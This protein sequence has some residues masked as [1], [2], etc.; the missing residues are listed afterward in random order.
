MKN[1]IQD[2]TLK[3][4]S[5]TGY[6]DTKWKT[7]LQEV[8]YVEC[9]QVFDDPDKIRLRFVSGNRERRF[10]LE[11]DRKTLTSVLDCVTGRVSIDFEKFVDEQ[12]NQPKKPK[13]S[14]PLR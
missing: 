3:V 10:E 13:K 7:V 11:F 1:S 4:R 8:L 14:G 6:R 12:N 2:T 5:R 9:K